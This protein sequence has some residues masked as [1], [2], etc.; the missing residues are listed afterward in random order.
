M[1]LREK[2]GTV[3][4][5]EQFAWPLDLEVLLYMLG[6]LVVEQSMRVLLPCQD[7]ELQS[8]LREK[9]VGAFEA[10]FISNL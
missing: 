7:L 2:R 3:P 6:R 1:P 8:F 5:A 4:V 9:Y 10:G